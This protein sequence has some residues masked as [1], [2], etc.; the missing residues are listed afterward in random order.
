MLFDKVGG[1]VMQRFVNRKSSRLI[2]ILAINRT[3]KVA[4]CCPSR[5]L[6]HGLGFFREKKD[7]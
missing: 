7:H 1:L 2:V 5:T 4:G 6:G 3:D